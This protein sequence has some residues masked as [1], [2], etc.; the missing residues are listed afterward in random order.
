VNE[1]EVERTNAVTRELEKQLP[2]VKL[3]DPPKPE[4]RNLESMMK[5]HSEV[6]KALVKAKKTDILVKSAE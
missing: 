5:H 3:P 2:G 6:L 4:E 1:L